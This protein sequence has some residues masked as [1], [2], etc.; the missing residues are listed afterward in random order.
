MPAE[1]A[2]EDPPVSRPVEEGAPALQLADPVGRLTRVEQGHAPV[3]EHLSADHRVA[4]MRLPGVTRGHVRER[5][6][7][8][9]LGHDGV[10]LAEEGLAHEPDRDALF[11]GFDRGAQAGAPGADDE[12][13]VGVTLEEGPHRKRCGSWMTPA[14][15]RRT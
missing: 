12:D 9:P 15:R 5:R 2:L 8:A 13:V 7:D 3:V 10:G 11:G 6:R 4:E 1:G 14:A